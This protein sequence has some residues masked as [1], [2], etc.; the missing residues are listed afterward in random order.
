VIVYPP[1][2]VAAA[3][4]LLAPASRVAG[5]RPVARDGQPAAS[6]AVAVNAGVGVAASGV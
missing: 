2:A 1:Q 3:D 5:K 4:R 6:V